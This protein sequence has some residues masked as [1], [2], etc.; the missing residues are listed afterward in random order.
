MRGRTTRVVLPTLVVLA[1]VGLV[2]IASTG[3]V[4]RGSGDSRPP[5]ESLLDTLFSLGLVAVVAGGVLF[6]YGLMQRKAI[7]QEVASGRY[8]RTSILTWLAFVAIFSALT[9]WRYQGWSPKA[10]QPVDEEPP[11]GGGP[12]VPTTPDQK[13]SAVYEPS[14]SW[15][16]IAVVVGLVLAAVV[17]YVVSERRAGKARRGGEQLAE[18]LAAVLDE[19]LD[20]LRA[21]ADPRRAIIAAYARME[22]VLAANGVA[23]RRSETSDEYLVRVLGDLALGSDAVARLTALFAQAKFSHH[24]I[25]AAM[26][27]EAIDALEQIRDELRQAEQSRG[28]P[29]VEARA[30]GGSP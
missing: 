17:A 11:F 7:A 3:S 4:P 22:R 2:A 10:Q 28:R 14:V 9:Y 8:R 13:P 25:D 1:L 6:L 5:S 30:V 15:V 26:K 19:A 20:D 27:E 16:P 24:D 21:L 12:I 29:A 23:R 18:D